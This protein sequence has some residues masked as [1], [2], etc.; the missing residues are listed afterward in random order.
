MRLVIIGAVAAGTS[1][2]A[3]AR[4]NNEELEIAIYEKDNLISYSGCGMPYYIGGQIKSMTELIPRDPAFFKSKYNIDILTGHEVLSLKPENKTLQVKNLLTG[5]IFTD[6]YD[7]LIIAT[8]AS[9]VI[10]P[11]KGAKNPNVFTLRNI[12][13]MNK[14]NSF[15]QNNR[16]KKAVIIGTGFIGLELCESFKNIGIDVTLIERLPQV[17]PGLDSDMAIYVQEYLEKN[18]VKVLTKANVSKITKNN[19]ILDN[20]EKLPADIVIMATGIKPNTDLAKNAGIELGITGAIKVNPRLETNIS[21]IY[22]CGDCME[23]YHM[24]SGQPVYRPLGSTANKTGRIAGEVVTGENNHFRGILGTGI[25]KV[26][27]LGI[28]QTGLSEKEALEQGYDISVIHN[29]KISRPEYMGGAEMIIKA[30]ANKKDAKLLGVQIIGSDGIDKRI[31]VFVTAI[32]FGAKAEDLIHLDLAY[33]PA[34][35]TAKD[36]VMYTGMILDNDINKGRS[37]ITPQKLDE[38]IKSGQRYRIIDARVD[39]NYNE[40]HVETA[41]NIP[42]AS[43]RET[44]KDIDKETI[45]ITYCNK[46]TT[47]NACQNILINRGLGKVFTLSGGHKHYKMQKRN[48]L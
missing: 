7:K 41:Q 21:N 18:G 26:F 3:K 32:T 13:D 44:I 14:I 1:A 43:L 40:D 37:L 47:G 16:P 25:F 30:I 46:G 45:T 11:I 5:K 4:R 22:A 42:H 24:V 9:A 36:P 2:A 38:L 28:A 15:I 33:S 17:T 23:H 48:F 35:S 20:D 10:P 8:G 12:G 19:V 34:F 27:E 6:H 39:S 29:T 31:D